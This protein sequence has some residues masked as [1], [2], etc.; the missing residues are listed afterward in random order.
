MWPAVVSALGTAL[1]AIGAT[2]AAE[3]LRE[4]YRRRAAPPPEGTNP[5]ERDPEPGNL[6]G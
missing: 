5:H 6:D 4:R 2:I 3:M 1:G